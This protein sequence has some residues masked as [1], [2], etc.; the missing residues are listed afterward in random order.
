[1]N[2]LLDIHH[3]DLFRS[4]YLLFNKRFGFNVYVPYGMEWNTDHGYANYP[5]IDTVK[6]YLL[7]V[8]HWI[9]IA[10]DLNEVNF[11][12]LDEYKDIKMDITVASLMENVKVFHD[13]NI[14]YNK[15]SKNI[16]QVGNNFPVNCID[17]FSKNLMSSS[18]VVYK[19]SSISHK[20][21]YHQEFDTNF[22]KPS[23]FVS[24]VN[25]VYSLQHYFGQGVPPYELDFRLFNELKNRMPDFCYKCFGLG[26]DGGD[27]CGI[28]EKI[29]NV[30]KNC[31]FIFHVKPQGDGYGHIYHNAFS[32][33]KPVIYK[34][35]YLFYNDI[36][37]TPMLLFD[38]DTSVDLSV[39][40]VD[41]AV[42]KITRMSSDYIR[43]TEKVHNKFKSV[44][45][46]DEEFVFIKKFIEDLQ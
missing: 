38:E 23:D 19:L 7:G 22:F 39:L 15:D 27:I 5:V 17:A 42:R 10:G 16:V 43:T 25:S 3:H 8:K 44:V 29:S 33:G 46:F 14:L 37:M 35:K 40:D 32:C 12:T 13:L 18:T 28:P 9:N 11:L 34:S 31:G 36:P 20:I 2:V 26:G 45:N 4:L 30:V 24:N 21:F 41:S 6:Q 1:M